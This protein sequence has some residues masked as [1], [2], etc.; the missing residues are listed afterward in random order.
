M[1]WRRVSANELRVKMRTFASESKIHFA[2]LISS[3]EIENYIQKLQNKNYFKWFI[4]IIIIIIII[5]KSL[6]YV[7]YFEKIK[8]GL[9]DH[10]AVCVFVYPLPYQFLT[11]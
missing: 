4:I 3:F 6:A 1:G 2:L 9:C 11:D 5:I 8:V 7:P 10:H